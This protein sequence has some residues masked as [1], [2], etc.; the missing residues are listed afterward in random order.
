MF[1][2]LLTAV[3]C[4]EEPRTEGIE[5][6]GGAPIRTTPRAPVPAP[7]SAPSVEVAAAEPVEE[8]EEAPVDPPMDPPGAVVE[9]APP[10][11]A[12]APPAGEP[13]AG[14]Q[15]ETVAEIV[16]EP[17][18][19]PEVPPQAEPEP[20]TP[21]EEVAAEPVLEPASETPQRFDVEKASEILVDI[22][23]D[24]DFPLEGFSVIDRKP[25]GPV[26]KGVQYVSWQ[27]LS[28][29]ELYGRQLRAILSPEDLGET[30][31]AEFPARIR[32]FDGK[33]I[34]LLGFMVPLEWD[35]DDVPELMLVR[36]LMSCCFGGVPMPDEWMHVRMVGK[37]KAE[38][39]P[40]VPVLVTGTLRLGGFRDEAGYTVG[41]YQ[42]E[43]VSLEEEAGW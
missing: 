31:A 35:G 6:R 18:P 21:I 32:A 38:Y 4:A 16:P 36:D 37:A 17:R 12:P 23:L 1:L 39:F 7:A 20:V 40:Y 22:S 3:G 25:T 2:A 30:E 5:V 13:V 24:G 26:P 28:L 33:K 27:D 29:R 41:C 15:A 42:L 8:A 10:E 19:Q 9:R 14:P 11:E 34:A 43:A